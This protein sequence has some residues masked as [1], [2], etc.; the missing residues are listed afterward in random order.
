[1]PKRLIEDLSRRSVDPPMTHG[2][3]ISATRCASES[4]SSPL[5]PLSL[6]SSRV[7]KPAGLREYCPILS[8]LNR[9]LLLPPSRPLASL[10]LRCAPHH[11]IAS[12]SAVLLSFKA[13]HTAKGWPSLYRAFRSCPATR[14]SKP[15]CR[16]PPSPRRTAHSRPARCPPRTSS[17]AWSA[18][19]SRARSCSPTLAECSAARSEAES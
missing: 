19:S 3:V 5:S 12:Q 4:H 14:P 2:G 6:Q 10:T 13:K 9:L 15:T 8:F 1:M 16:F 17:T 18:N 11:R 7:S